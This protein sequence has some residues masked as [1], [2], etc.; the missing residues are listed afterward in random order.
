MKIGRVTADFL[1]CFVGFWIRR[2]QQGGASSE[3]LI[4][5]MN[6]GKLLDVEEVGEVLVNAMLDE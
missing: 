6:I 1:T 5:A 4:A 3:E 2:K